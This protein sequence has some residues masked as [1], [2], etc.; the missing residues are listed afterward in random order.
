[1]AGQSSRRQHGAAGLLHSAAPHNGGVENVFVGIDEVAGRE[2]D[3]AVVIDVLRAFTTAA[4]VLKRGA[5]ALYLADTDDAALALAAELGPEAV[6]L[7]DAD[8]HPGFGLANSP[9]QISRTDLTGCVVV[10]RTT[11]GSVGA[12]AAA[13]LPLVVCAGLVTATATARTLWR[14]G[15]R[16]VL[17]VV[18]GAS[19]TA[20]EDLAC[21]EL[22]SA[23]AAGR[24]P[25]PEPFRQRVRRSPAA[26]HLERELAAGHPGIHE[27]DVGLC[28]Q[29]DR[30]DFAPTAHLEDDRLRLV[31]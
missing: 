20:D 1:M 15:A 9:G 2:A 23:L 6:A 16:R 5:R 14:S 17:Y 7:K 12:H 24:R 30:F 29:V 10:Q 13:H 21:A 22:I 4:W 26:A 31:R 11:N 27:D 8:P 19:G 25:D 3:A 28:A 18:T